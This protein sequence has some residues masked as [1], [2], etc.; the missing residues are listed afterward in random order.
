MILS[1]WLLLQKI[2]LSIIQAKNFPHPSRFVVLA[3]IPGRTE[4][5]QQNRSIFQTQR[6]FR[7]HWLI[8]YGKLI[9]RN[10]SFVKMTENDCNQMMIT[11]AR[12]LDF[13]FGD[14]Y[15]L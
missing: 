11:E 2:P 9:A 7:L 13:L 12:V 1:N 4:K 15:P 10:Q 5:S 8:N 14:Y 3:Q 6:L